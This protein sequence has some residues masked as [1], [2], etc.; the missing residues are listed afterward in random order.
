MC[1][2]AQQLLACLPACLIGTLLCAANID[3]R[4]AN[5]NK[6]KNKKQK[7][8]QTG[9]TGKFNQATSSTWSHCRRP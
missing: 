6:K 5:N 7:N 4:G 3:G 9:A 8:K 2:A 1:G